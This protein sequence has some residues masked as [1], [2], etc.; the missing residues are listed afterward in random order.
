MAMSEGDSDKGKGAQKWGK[1]YGRRL[2]MAPFLT[3]V[4]AVPEERRE[5]GGA[6]RR[7]LTRWFAPD[8]PRNSSAVV[9]VSA[10][11]VAAVVTVWTNDF[12]NERETQLPRV[13]SALRL[14]LST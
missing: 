7:V 11:I 3:E 5:G 1:N 6:M 9:R 13:G 12:L 4:T 2:S 8:S 10:A 14:P